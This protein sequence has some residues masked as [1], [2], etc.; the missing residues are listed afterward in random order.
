MQLR[1]CVCWTAFAGVRL[2]EYVA[3]CWTAIDLPI[4]SVC[5]EC[6]QSATGVQLG[7]QF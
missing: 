5:C 2:V 6:D 3:V 7:V 4:G 1:E